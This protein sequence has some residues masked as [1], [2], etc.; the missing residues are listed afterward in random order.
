MVN[1]RSFTVSDDL[2]SGFEVK[3]DLDLVENLD[4]IVSLVYNKLNNALG[5]MSA[6]TEILR[7]RNFHIHDLTFEQILMSE[8]STFFY[9]C[10]HCVTIL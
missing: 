8:P 2:F 3:V 7:T 5:N 10:S 1:L 4:D 9:I 6:L